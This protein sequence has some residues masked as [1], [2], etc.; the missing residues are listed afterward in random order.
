MPHWAY[1]MM[2]HQTDYLFA[3]DCI[4]FA[5]G[6]TFNPT[7]STSVLALTPHARVA[8]KTNY[9]LVALQRTEQMKH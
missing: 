2:M 4:H 1:T 8:T 9:L 7:G 5:V 3:S 6:G